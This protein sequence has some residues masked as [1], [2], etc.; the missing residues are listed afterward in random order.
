MGNFR[1]KWG[2]T[3]KINSQSVPTI[4]DIDDFRFFLLDHKYYQNYKKVYHSWHNLVASKDK[5]TLFRNGGGNLWWHNHKNV[6]SRV[7]INKQL[8]F[9]CIKTVKQLNNTRVATMVWLL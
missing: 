1:L 4:W 3:K 8:Y 7:I 5:T 6:H 2:D 9:L